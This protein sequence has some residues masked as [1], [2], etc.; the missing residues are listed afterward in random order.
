MSLIEFKNLPDTTTPL[1]AEN[2][3][4]NFNHFVDELYYKANDEYQPG[5]YA[6]SGFLSGASKELQIT[7]P[8]PKSMANV[9]PQL[10]Y[11]DIV[12][13]GVGGYVVARTQDNT[14]WSV[15]KNGDYN[16]TLSYSSETALGTNNTPVV[17]T[18]YTSFKIK[19]IEQSRNRE[20][21][22]IEEPEEENR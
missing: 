1:T 8:T 13:R 17:A 22:N 10:N 18:L 19:F 6:C 12:V 14:G 9:T 21:S 4:N 11:L 15:T 3:N 20:N 7:I 16:I 5:Y 2:L